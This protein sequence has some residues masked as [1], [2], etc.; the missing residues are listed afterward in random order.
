V[1]Q[2]LARQLRDNDIQVTVIELNME[3]VRRLHEHGRP[4]VYGDASRAETLKSAGIERARFLILSASDVPE[5][6]EVIRAAREL[7]PRIHILARAAFVPQVPAL[8]R[9]GADTVFSAEGEVALAMTEAILRALG[10]T[11]DQIDRERERV[12]AEMTGSAVAEA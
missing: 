1:G 8:W 5:A 10:A 2:T 4:A 12:H 11:P 6:V 3:T 9:A 7:N